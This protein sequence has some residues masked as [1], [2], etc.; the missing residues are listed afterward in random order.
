MKRGTNE[1]AHRPRSLLRTAQHTQRKTGN[2]CTGPHGPGKS[3]KTRCCA[4]CTCGGRVAQGAILVLFALGFILGPG[5]L[6]HLLEH[7][8][9]L[10]FVARQHVFGARDAVIDEGKLLNP[11]TRRA[12]EVAFT[13][14]C[15]GPAPEKRAEGGG[16]AP[17]A[18]GEV[19]RPPRVPARKQRVRTRARTPW[20]SRVWAL[21]LD[22][23]TPC[24]PAGPPAAGAPGGW[25]ARSTG[26]RWRARGPRGAIDVHV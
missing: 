20:R 22:A 26:P 15:R 6:A 12:S 18:S 2:R 25:M 16:P 23:E 19:P 3:N 8:A 14:R 11:T 1:G 10:H 9:Q 5:A 21:T 24:A 7:L 17:E 4:A 13:P